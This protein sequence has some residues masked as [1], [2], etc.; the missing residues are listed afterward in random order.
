MR[1]TSCLDDNT[2]LNLVIQNSFVD[3]PPLDIVMLGAYAVGYQVSETEKQFLRKAYT[4]CAALLCICAGFLPVLAA[5]ILEGKTLTAP[6][7]MLPMMRQAAPGIKWVTRRWAQDGKVWTT[8]SLLN[9]M[10]M[11]AAFGRHT[12][13]GK[14][15]LVDH[16]IRVGYWPERDVDYADVRTSRL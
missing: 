15:S 14:D 1:E 3:C 16:M 4:E 7:P 5:G 8:G 6:I 11:M 2:R 12:W 9:G 10:D 13:G